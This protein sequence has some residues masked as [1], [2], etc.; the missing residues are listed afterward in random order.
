[1]LLAFNKSHKITP[2]AALCRNIRQEVAVLTSNFILQ[3]SILQQLLEEI[4]HGNQESVDRP[5]S[6]G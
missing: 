1:M 4:K 3:Q 2:T 6:Q 5:K